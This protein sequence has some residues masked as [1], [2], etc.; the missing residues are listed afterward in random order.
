MHEVRRGDVSLVGGK[1]AN[2]GELIHA[3]F[4]VPDGFVLTT[5]AYRTV[6]G[7]ARISSDMEALKMPADLVQAI[8]R[9]YVE[10]PVGPVAVRSSATS[11]DLPGAAFAGQHDTYLNID[12]ADDVIAAVR[13]CWASL[14][15]ERAVAYRN[16]LGIKS[17]TVAMAV[18]VQSMVPADTAG[19]MFTADPV[20]GVRDHVVIDAAGGLGEAVVSGD[21]IPEHFVVAAKGGVIGSSTGRDT[22]AGESAIVD[23]DQ[24]RELAAVGRRIAAHF[25]QPQ[26]IEWALHSGRLF[27]L[28]SRA[29]TALPPAP[30][31]L[32]RLRRAVGSII[33]ELLPRRPF[34]MELTAWIVPVVGAHLSDMIDGVSGVAVDVK[35]VLPERDG[36]IRELVPPRPHPTRRTPIRLAGSL[37]RGLRRTPRQWQADPRLSAY[38]EG[39]A[40][41][42]KRDPSSMGWDEL[43]AVVG[44]TKTLVDIVTEVRIDYLPAA[45]VTLAKFRLATL[46]ARRR[47]NVQEVLASAP[48]MTRAANQEL[49]ALA[50]TADRIP[51]LRALLLNSTQEVAAERA[52][53]L[54]TG[55]QWW[56]QFQAFLARYGHRETTS[57]LLVH[58]PTWS[59]S[60]ST[61]I[62]LIQVLLTPESAGPPSPRS[63]PAA[64]ASHSVL[65]QR[66]ARGA[67]SAVALRED[68][69]F[70]LSRVVPIIR[71]AIMEMGRRLVAAGELEDTEDVWMLTLSEVTHFSRGTTGDGVLG[72][73]AR[74]RRIA[75]G[76]QAATPLIATATLYPRRKGSGAMLASGAAGGG[77]RATGRVRIIGGPADFGTLRAGEVLVC[78]ATNPSWTPLF[79]RAAAVVV[80]RGGMASHAAIVAREYGIP[81]VMGAGTAT[82]SLRTGQLVMVDG[83]LGEVNAAATES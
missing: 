71:G 59:E 47:I 77:G 57:I 75:Q 24:L 41:M 28:Q 82:Q 68:T 16:R 30:I 78:Q 51:E 40:D 3:G 64:T 31:Q 19:V 83:D 39:V 50:R 76:E 6:V 49:L 9:A 20:S 80:D 54:A 29:M 17:D 43:V 5:D 14:F 18:V 53:L 4:P 22:T 44:R 72:G 52:P 2:L 69:H 73:A 34:P 65:M 81:A 27:I 8:N 7:G 70:E 23:D 37:G 36:M 60:P 32:N 79:L 63:S 48:T 26:E 35:K 61:V 33:L 67:A 45:F 56:V 46:L 15:S 12:G 58:D 11:E 74:R 38:R 55:S 13:R 10:L 25:G 66:L 1:A 21:V 62:G 42:I